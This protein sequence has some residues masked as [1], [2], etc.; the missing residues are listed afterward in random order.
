MKESNTARTEF[1]DKHPK[2]WELAYS[3]MDPDDSDIMVPRVRKGD[4]SL[5]ASI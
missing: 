1:P 3:F 2:E 4:G 5:R